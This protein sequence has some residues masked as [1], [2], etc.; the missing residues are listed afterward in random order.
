MDTF[1]FFNKNFGRHLTK[2]T[3]NA[4]ADVQTALSMN[5]Q[6]LTGK[7]SRLASGWAIIRPGGSSLQLGVK[8]SGITIVGNTVSRFEAFIADL[9]AWK[10]EP[11]IFLTF[12]KRPVPIASLFITYDLRAV[13]ICSP[14]GVETF[15]FTKPPTDESGM[16]H[17]GLFKQMNGGK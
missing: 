2:Q 14:K 6:L 12:D 8:C 15:D 11:R 3:D 17:K 7:G 1:D 5:H 10:N 9:Q 16:V 4:L 13:R